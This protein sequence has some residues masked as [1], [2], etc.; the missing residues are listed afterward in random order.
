MGN[1]QQEQ[2]IWIKSSEEDLWNKSQF[3]TNLEYI[4]S[5]VQQIHTDT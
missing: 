2:I 3:F 5:G 4:C 1:L